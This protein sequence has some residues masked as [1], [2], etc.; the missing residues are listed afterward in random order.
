MTRTIAELDRIELAESINR[1]N[2]ALAVPAS[3]FD[4]FRKMA[5]DSMLE[6][7]CITG[8][9]TKNRYFVRTKGGDWVVHQ[10][11]V[12]TRICSSCK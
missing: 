9:G 4:G 12:W 3:A 1:S 10:D 8:F 11:Q 2:T 7:H 5:K 6:I